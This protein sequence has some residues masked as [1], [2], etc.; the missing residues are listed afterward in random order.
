MCSGPQEHTLNS[1]KQKRRP[2]PPRGNLNNIRQLNTRDT[3][4]RERMRFNS[5]IPALIPKSAQSPQ[6]S[7]RPGNKWGTVY[8]QPRNSNCSITYCGKLKTEHNP[9]ASTV[10]P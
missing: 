8:S 2:T 6:Q 7:H 10:W 5:V 3:Q 4:T 1:G 9:R